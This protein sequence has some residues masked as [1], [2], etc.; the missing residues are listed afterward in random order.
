MRAQTSWWLARTDANASVQSETRPT[1]VI[2]AHDHTVVADETKPS[3]LDVRR[4]R[5]FERDRRC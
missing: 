2:Y 5:L 4:E 3:A 1:S